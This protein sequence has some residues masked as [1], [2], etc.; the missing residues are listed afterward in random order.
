MK[1]QYFLT[2]QIHKGSNIS[3]EDDAWVMAEGTDLL[4]KNLHWL[5]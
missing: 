3:E 4:S 5:F 1:K 2:P